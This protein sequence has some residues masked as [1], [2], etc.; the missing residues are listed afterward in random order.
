[1]PPLAQSIQLEDAWAEVIIDIN[2]AIP[3]STVCQTYAKYILHTINP[4][5]SLAIG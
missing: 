5:C 4:I 2:N 3:P 1:M